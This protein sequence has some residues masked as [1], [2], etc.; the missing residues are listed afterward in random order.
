M[1]AADG[2]VVPSSPT[3]ERLPGNRYGVY[4][5]KIRISNQYRFVSES[6]ALA[7]AGGAVARRYGARRRWR[8]G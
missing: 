6:Y 8:L 3:I 2:L 5:N 4:G 7:I 1:R